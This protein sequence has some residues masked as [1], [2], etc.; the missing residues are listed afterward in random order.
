MLLEQHMN[1]P[2]WLIAACLAASVPVQA[3]STFKPVE[4][5]DNEMAELRGRYVMPDGSSVS[6]L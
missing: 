6:A 5:K 2:I 3:A 4:L 1:T